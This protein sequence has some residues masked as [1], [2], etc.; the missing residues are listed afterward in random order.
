MLSPPPIFWGFC[1]FF[2]TEIV[3]KHK[4][5]RE[6]VLGQARTGYHLGFKF[7]QVFKTSQTQRG[8][9]EPRCL[10]ITN[11]TIARRKCNVSLPHPETVIPR[12]LHSEIEKGF[13]GL[14]MTLILA[15]TTVPDPIEMEELKARQQSG[16]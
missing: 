2:F 10:L 5:C 16:L 7:K 13:K 9:G 3:A 15:N 8:P 14:S 6:I 1:C 11:G 12:E 4:Q